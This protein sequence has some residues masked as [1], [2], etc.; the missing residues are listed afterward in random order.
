M[1][2]SFSVLAALL[3][4]LSALPLFVSCAKSGAKI[5]E[6]VEYRQD[7]LAANRT[8][9]VFYENLG[10]DP[11]DE[12]SAYMLQ[13][14]T[15][16]A[17]RTEI[18]RTR[19]EADAVFASCPAVDFGEEMLVVCCFT[20]VYRRGCELEEVKAGEGGALYIRFRA[21]R[22]T[23]IGDASMPGQGVVTIRMPAQ[24][25]TSVHPAYDE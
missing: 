20:T 15:S 3:A 6:D 25:V 24:N 1:K 13:D 7:W 2:K 18:V 10:Y 22:R 16:P 14:E 19:A 17:Y 9:G 5:V 21:K 8:R 23:G 11:E 4:L 12:D